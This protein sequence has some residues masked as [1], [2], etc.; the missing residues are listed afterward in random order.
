M[1]ELIQPAIELLS[2]NSYFAVATA[3][4]A[5][6]STVSAVIPAPKEGTFLSKAFGVINF[7]ALNIFNAKNKN[8]K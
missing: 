2:G 5:V 7:L 1:N 6:A 3:I 8:V 4:I